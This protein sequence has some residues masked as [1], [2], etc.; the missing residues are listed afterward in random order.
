MLKKWKKNRTGLGRWTWIRI[1][2]NNEIK[3]TVIT[4]YSPCKT[5]KQSYYSTYAQQKKDMGQ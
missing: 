2:G 1:E 4:V 5:R 3:T